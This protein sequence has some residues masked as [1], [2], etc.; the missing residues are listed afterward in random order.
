[1]RF[2]RFC[3]SRTTYMLCLTLL[4]AGCVTTTEG[5]ITTKKAPQGEWLEPSP[6]LRQ[7]I[8]DQAERLPW[9]HGTERV[10]Q[11]HWF[12]TVGEPAYPKLLQLV[13]D[14]RPGVAGSA[15]AALGAT[16]DSRLVTALRQLPVQPTEA[17][18]LRYERAR[19]F[20]RLG[21]WRDVPV[22]IE[23]LRNE[24]TMMRA[25]CA[26]ALFEATGERLDY[27]A[28]DPA[29]IRDQAVLSWEAWWKDRER[30]GILNANY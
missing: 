16:R 2:Q 20:L 4:L 9:T 21:D 6:L 25:L 8:E 11:I 26:Q 13:Q 22:L 7:Q 14:Q 23:G 3:A 18:A 5:M 19:T 29:L 1:M 24:S 30:E 10:E 17:E 12:A 15:L 27:D 28:K